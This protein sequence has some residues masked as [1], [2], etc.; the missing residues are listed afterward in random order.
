MKLRLLFPVAIGIA[1]HASANEADLAKQLANPVSSLISVPLQGNA[2]FDIGPGD[3]SRLTTN[4]QPV[5]PTALNDQWNLISRMILPFIDQDGILPGDA[6]D[7]TGL[8]DTLQSLFFSPQ[9]SDPIWGAG[10][11]C[12]MPTAT[13]SVLGADQWALGPTAVILKQNGPWTCGFLTNHLWHVA[14]DEDNGAINATYLQPFAAYITRTKTTFTFNSESSYDWN[15]HQW[16]APVNFIVSQLLKFGDQPVQLF[17]GMRWHA[18]TP[19]GGPDWG[20][21]FGLT[22]L[23]PK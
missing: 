14:G 6:A 10:P 16:S 19:E 21:R 3:G 12:L 13:D 7:A 4:F 18:E 11:A 2:D 20:L 5:I 15:D 22:F 17:A 1:S 23:F 8:G 9:A